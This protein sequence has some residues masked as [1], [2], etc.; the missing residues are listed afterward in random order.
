MKKLI[1]LFAALCL[2]AV[3]LAAMPVTASAD[4]SGDWEYTVKAGQAT[5]T[6]YNGTDAVVTVPELFEDLYQVV[7]IGPNAFKDNTTMTQIVFPKKLSS[8]GESAFEGCVS[9]VELTLPETLKNLGNFSFRGC[10]KLVKIN[11]FSTAL[12]DIKPI[13]KYGTY[14]D[15]INYGQPFYNAGTAGEGI[16]VIFADGSRVPAHLFDAYSGVEFAANVISVTFEDGVR[17]IGAFAFANCPG[18]E[19]INLGTVTDIGSSAFL[20][21]TD[22]NEITWSDD[23]AVIGSGA[24]QSCTKIST[25]QLPKSL[26]T[27]GDDAFNGCTKLAELDLPQ[28]LSTI[29]ARAFIECLSLTD[30]TL[31]EGLTSIGNN[32]F[33]GC[34]KL[35]KLTVN[36][37]ALEDIKS[38]LKYGTYGDVVGYDEPFH[39]AGT[40]ADGIEVVFGESCTRI[41]ANMFY[42]FS[43]PEN[44][45]NIVSVSISDETQNGVS[46]IG[47]NAFRSCTSLESF[48]FGSAVT[49][50][51]GAFESC[52]GLKSFNWSEKLASIGS[53]AFKGCTKIAS[54]SLPASLTAID[55][56]AFKG[57][58]NL[59]S[60]SFPAGLTSIGDSAFVDCVN[61]T[62]LT[63][64]EKLT[65]LGK[66]CFRGCTG[67][68]TVN[69][70]SVALED[71]KS[72][73]KYGTY[74][75][76]V[77]YYQPFCGIGT[78]GTG[79]TVSFSDTCTRIPANM[80]H[81]YSGA[82]TSPVINKLIVGKGVT[83]I[84]D[85]AFTN[86]DELSEIIFNCPTPTM[87]ENMFGGV[88]ATAYHPGW[89]A[90][91]RKDYGGM[92]TWV[93]SENCIH[94]E[95][96]LAN[97]KA[98]DCLN[99]GYT[100]DKVCTVCGE[101]V[102]IGTA[103][104]ALDHSFGEYVSD[105]NATCTTDGTK[106]AGC[107][108]EGCS[109]T[110]T[111]ADEG[112]ATGH[113]YEDGKCN[114]C[115]GD[116]PDYVEDPCAEGHEYED[117]KCTRCGKDDPDY[118]EDPC[119]KGH[120]YGKWTITKMFTCTE[121]GK[122]SRSCSVC[123][124]T[125]DFDVEAIG[126]QFTRELA[127]E[128]YLKTAATE[129]EPAVYFK[130][131]ACGEKG[132]ETFVYEDKKPEEEKP[133]EEKPG[134]E[135]PQ[136]DAVNIVLKIDDPTI[137][138]NGKTSNIDSLGT[139]PVILN[140]R[141]LLPI[142]C[143]IEA[144]GG[145]VQWDPNVRTVELTLKDKVLTLK[146]DSNFMWDDVETIYIDTPPT[147]IGDRTMVPLRAVV[148]YFG[149]SVNWDGVTKTITINYENK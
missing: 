29:G 126:H 87:A 131:C 138:V 21:C 102:E 75:D 54:L 103:T 81:A 66:E 80:F 25:L 112:S 90:E 33:K 8:I 59:S 111:V 124:V 83:E 61:L 136:P 3:I 9:L 99:P 65:S 137:T 72:I 42:A 11:I 148:E 62:E 51:T 52:T 144:M 86:C 77:G 128:Y 130:S 31:N 41:P 30:V 114:Q 85:N 140:D 145:S 132:T 48:D 36:S 35:T 97:E 139:S 34:T 69:V 39:T 117:G 67:I 60:I 40:A 123:G 22:L 14:G 95:T 91:D 12:E 57:C 32:A 7:A 143:V 116:D 27:I 110:D 63:L 4:S 16:E 1:S 47:S 92:I 17:E 64:P 127:I 45:A 10:T 108:R 100:G 101:T 20:K 38:I 43:G 141:T 135:E 28:K 18:I 5:V 118:V 79:V 147:I 121:N 115:G 119:S 70:N 26:T 113:K 84:G 122:L 109:V 50:G 24:F 104:E 49:I 133:D 134:E 53:D 44:A 89:P 149:A 120:S 78:A 6:K 37:I 82:D 142:R 107:T 125:E 129:E 19:K 56:E 146:I 93:L 13:L 88:V 105:G 46:E 96:E 55:K 15:V 98:A 2:C 106:T 94:A 74:G 71:I 73:L 68:S 76:V 23:L 58:T